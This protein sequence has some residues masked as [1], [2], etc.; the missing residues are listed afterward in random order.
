MKHFIYILCTIAAVV[1]LGQNPVGAAA[2]GRSSTIYDNWFFGNNNYCVSMPYSG[3][4]AYGCYWC[5][6]VPWDDKLGCQSGFPGGCKMVNVGETV[7]GKFKCTSASNGFCYS[8]CPD[9]WVPDPDDEW[10]EN[11]QTAKDCLCE[12]YENTG[13]S[14]CVSGAIEFT[15]MC[16]PNCSYMPEDNG[17]GSGQYFDP[18]DRKCH[19]CPKVTNEWGEP[20]GEMNGIHI[21][22]ESDIE[23]MFKNKCW[24]EIP[25]KYKDNTGD[26]TLKSNDGEFQCFYNN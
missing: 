14:R 21:N 15:G 12:N 8:S 7:D 4:P 22:N 13:D 3:K 10:R 17:Y 9:K 26:F 2:Q 6:A 23:Q 24:I 18:G 19:D 1:L 16:I 11:Y 5:L 25:G 20:A